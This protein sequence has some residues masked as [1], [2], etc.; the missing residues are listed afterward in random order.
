MGLEEL[1]DKISRF[2]KKVIEKTDEGIQK[3]KGSEEAGDAKEV[4][5]KVVE[6]AVG[7]KSRIIKEGTAFAKKYMKE[8]VTQENSTGATIGAFGEYLVKKTAKGVK[9]AAEALTD[10][11][12]NEAVKYHKKDTFPELEAARSLVNEYAQD[13]VEQG[14]EEL[15]Y[16]GIDLIIKRTDRDLSINLKNKQKKIELTYFLKDAEIS[17]LNYE[18][19]TLTGDLLKRLDK[20]SDPATVKINKTTVLKMDSPLNKNGK[21][22][23]VSLKKI[24]G[25]YEVGYTP[26]NRKA[27]VMLKYVQ[28]KE[29]PCHAP[30]EDV[31]YSQDPIPDMLKAKPE[32]T[33][34]Q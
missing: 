30:E 1:A 5:K 27:G 25:A 12:E 9:A 34:Q 29:I 28:E 24:D 6:E 17:D 31:S 18:F 2:K 20:L 19:D 8:N 11:I 15:N 10:Y 7:L 13:N 32:D 26:E 23:T 3:L 14:E 22:Y 21:V 4:G 16:K 33:E